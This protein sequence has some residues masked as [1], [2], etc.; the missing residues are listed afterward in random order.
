MYIVLGLALLLAPLDR[1]GAGDTA[2]CKPGKSEQKLF[3][4]PDSG[5]LASPEEC[6]VGSKFYDFCNRWLGNKNGFASKNVR[7]KK[8]G[9]SCFKEY[10]RFDDAYELKIT[11]T[12]GSPFYVGTLKYIEKVFRTTGQPAGPGAESFALVDEVPVTEFFMFKNDKWCY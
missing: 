10:S 5:K 4:D 11:K 8:E 6:R 2:V 3:I 9:N 1:A 7:V 12:P